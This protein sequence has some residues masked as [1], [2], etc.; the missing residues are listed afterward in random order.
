MTN[1]IV[2][3]NNRP[4]VNEIVESLSPLPTEAIVLGM[5]DDGLPVLFNTSTIFGT[6]PNI[7]IW[8]GEVGFLKSVAE[9]ILN[10]DPDEKDEIEFVVF[11]RNMEEWGF[12]ADKSNKV[13]NSPCIGVIPFWSDL[14]DQVLLGLA[15][16]IHQGIHP[17][18]SV[19]VLIEGVENILK[20]DVSAKQ[21]FHYIFLSGGDRQVFAIGTVPEGLDLY[22]LQEAFKYQGTFNK[23]SDTYEFPEGENT[24]QVWIPRS[25]L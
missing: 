9:F 16:W 20:M 7:M 12:L 3:R 11:T 17:N 1:S 4:T 23:E 5:A 15:S 8:N 24:I 2:K 19:I 25:E 22:G 10:R 13:R 21:N 6:S 18:H 14:A